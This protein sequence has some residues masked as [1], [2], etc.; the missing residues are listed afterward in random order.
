MG[1][2]QSWGDAVGSSRSALPGSP[3]PQDAPCVSPGAARC[4]LG[5]GVSGPQQLRF[6][7]GNA[8]KRD[9]DGGGS[10]KGDR[11][12]K[13]LRDQLKLIPRGGLD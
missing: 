6:F 5:R 9:S 8:A 2:E 3:S 4:H 11:S 13:E 12:A 7:S 10:I 1:Q